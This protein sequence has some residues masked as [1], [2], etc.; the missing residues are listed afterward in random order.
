M[1]R[2]QA[3]CE[4]KKDE[5]ND[6]NN[7]KVKDDVNKVKLLGFWQSSKDMI[8]EYSNMPV[9]NIEL[10]HE[11]DADYFVIISKPP[12]NEYYN[13]KRTI[14][15]QMEPWV[16]DMSKPWGVK[17]WGEWAK[18]DTSLFMHVHSHDKYLNNV[19]WLLTLGDIP[20]G[21]FDK[22]CSILSQKNYDIGHQ[23]RIAF[24][25]K[26]DIVEVYGKM[27]YH[28]LSSYIGPVEKEN[29]F[30]VYSKYKYVLAVENNS[31]FNYASEKIWEPILCECL[32][33][34]WGCP[35][36][37]DYIDPNCF[38]SLPLEEPEKA[39]E[40]IQQV[41]REDWW[42]QRIELIRKVK[43]RIINEMG[44]FPTISRIIKEKE[45]KEKENKK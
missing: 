6:E 10:T 4:A 2:E 20:A 36:L 28:K 15:F 23:L 27:N 24:A 11:D 19:Q 5:N 39:Y 38:V 41:I 37:E 45:E 21:K 29:T 43:N 40:I 35:N 22:V 3:E 25:E 9:G 34:Y 16:H 8:K 32:A 30:N 42:S 13:P 18:P 1:L 14:I 26:Y 17:T 12:P 44:M 7:D 31:E 33:F